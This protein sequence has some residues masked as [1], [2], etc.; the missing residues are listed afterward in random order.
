MPFQNK[1]VFFHDFKFIINEN[2]YEPAEDS[3]LFAENLDVKNG[4]KVLDMGVGCGIL[5]ILSTRKTK[6]VVGI[7]INPYAVHCAKRNAILNNAKGCIS[8][9]QGDLFSAL[10]KTEKFDLIL[11]NAPYL[12]E[13]ETSSLTWLERAW[14]GGLNG[15]KV[16]DVFLSEA[17]YHLT[18]NGRIL[19][20]Q[21]TLSNVKR[22]LS[23]LSRDKLIVKI[24]AEVKIPFFETIVLI[25]AMC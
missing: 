16:I 2:V 25:E 1:T 13:S 22:T 21:S 24:I 5:G 6:D 18:K 11:F 17:I 19:L 10:K 3:F 23:R 12:P 4:E 8:F 15:R 20:L 9:I 14:I 7:D